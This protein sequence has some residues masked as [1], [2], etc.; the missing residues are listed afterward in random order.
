MNLRELIQYLSCNPETLQKLDISGNRGRIPARIIPDLIH[1][2]TNLRELNVAGCLIGTVPEPLIPCEDLAHMSRLRELDISQYKVNDATI[3]ALEEYLQHRST[4]LAGG[5]V[6]VNHTM[7]QLTLN[8]CG[9]TGTQAGQL[10]RAIGEN[11]G[12]SISLNGN[13]LEEGLEDMALAIQ[14]QKGPEELHMDMIEFRDEAK[15]R[16]LLRA[17]SVTRYLTVLSL[18]GTTPTPSIGSALHSD[19]VGT[20]EIFFVRNQSIR[21]LDFS[22]Y[23][24]KLDEG[25]MGKGF[26][27]A[28]RGLANNHTLTHLRIRNQNLSHNDIGTLGQALRQNHTLQMLDCQD[29][30]LNMSTLQFLI[31]A[32]KESRSL[33]EFVFEP[34]EKARVWHRIRGSLK[35]PMPNGGGTTKGYDPE[36][37]E[38]ILYKQY[39]AMLSDLE[40]HL[41]S[42][43]ERPS[44]QL[45]AGRDEDGDDVFTP[46]P[47]DANGKGV[48][49]GW[50]SHQRDDSYFGSEDGLCLVNPEATPRANRRQATV[51][52]SAI[53]LDTDVAAPYHV[54]PG[55]G[56]ESPIELMMASPVEMGSPLTPEEEEEEAEGFELYQ[57]FNAMQL[58]SEFDP[59]GG[60]T[61][62]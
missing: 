49:R 41:E 30:G 40:T 14:M 17:L 62:H 23:C 28:L 25:Q 39:E 55:E 44:P 46:R 29:N 12:M 19:T 9:V 36:G 42:N 7:R 16:R 21:Y 47:H 10:F 50:G 4:Q 35:G 18:V 32:I 61:G 2:F 3:S 1:L 31:S 57:K 5:V 6:K 37:H 24:G 53:A 58:A 26:G 33:T 8:H 13:P 60:P 52:S 27:T 59:E 11:N 56:M 15:F 38:G 51:K 54:R 20:I 45:V 22:G 43:R 48:S 34:D